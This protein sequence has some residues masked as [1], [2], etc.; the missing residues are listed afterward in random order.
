MARRDRGDRSAP[1]EGHGAGRGILQR[2]HAVERARRA[3]PAGRL[4][5]I[6]DDP[7]AIHRDAAKLEMQQA[8]DRLH[9]GVGDLLREHQ[10]AGLR[11]GGEHGGGT[12]LG[13]AGDDDPVR[14]HLEPGSADP[15]RPHLPVP[16]HAGRGLVEVHQAVQVR[17]SG[18][19]LQDVAHRPDSRIAHQPALAQVDDQRVLAFDRALLQARFG[20]PYEGAAADLAAHHSP[21]LGDRVGAAHRAD[22]HAEPLGEIALGGKAGTW[23]EE[24]GVDV[25]LEGVEEGLVLGLGVPGDGGVPHCHNDNMTIDTIQVN[26]NIVQSTH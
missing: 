7:F 21:L 24:P 4:E 10:V 9:P 15:P 26:S 17:P 12:M 11:E 25:V 16:R 19:A 14:G 2:R 13:A 8:R 1:S 3:F 6:G 20:T 23:G 18:E 5:G 22:G